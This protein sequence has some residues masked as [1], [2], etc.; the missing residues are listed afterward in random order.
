MRGHSNQCCVWAC[1]GMATIPMLRQFSMEVKLACASHL[2]G[3]GDEIG[4]CD[5]RG[6]DTLEGILVLVGCP[7]PE[8]EGERAVPREPTPVLQGTPVLGETD[9]DDQLWAALRSNQRAVECR[10]LLVQPMSSGLF[11]PRPLP[12]LHRRPL[13]RERYSTR[14]R[15]TARW[16]RCGR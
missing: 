3:I 7:F 10:K 15:S 12:S 9:Q 6:H 16:G 8:I 2:F 1:L 14:Q 4:Q 5:Q 13:D 11:R